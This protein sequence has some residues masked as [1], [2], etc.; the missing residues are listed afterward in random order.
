[1]TIVATFQIGKAGLTE[2]V[3]E[4]LLAALK[5]HRQVRIS[6]LQSSGRDRNSMES[7]AEDMKNM[8]SEKQSGNYYT[9]IIGFT[10][11]LK[12]ASSQK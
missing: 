7:L 1:M 8:L 3:I 12:K 6:V 11:I 2:G 9:K 10:I 5:N 4:S